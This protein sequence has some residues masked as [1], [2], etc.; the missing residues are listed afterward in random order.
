MR[1]RCV[2]TKT[3][4]EHCGS[5]DSPCEAK[6]NAAAACVAG[7]CAVG[8]CQTGFGNCD[9]NAE[10]GCE[11]DTTKSKDH[12]GACE[13]KC[14]TMCQDSV[15]ND[16]IDITAGNGHTCAILKDGSVWCWGTNGEGQ[17][18]VGDVSNRL[19]PTKVS[20]PGPATAVAAGVGFGLDPGEFE[21]HTCAILADKSLYCWGANSRGQLGTGDTTNA[22]TP[23][24]A[25]LTD[26]TRLSVGGQHTCATRANND[27]Y[28][29]G[30]NNQGQIGDGTTT[31]RSVPTKVDSFVG[32]FDAGYQHTCRVEPDGDNLNCW[33]DNASGQ[34]GDGTTNDALSPNYVLG[35]QDVE[36][37]SLGEFFSCARTVTTVQ[38]WGSNESGKLGIGT[39]TTELTPQTLGTVGF[40]L[41]RT[42]YAHA[43]G[44]AAGKVVMWGSNSGGQLGDNS[45]TDS[46]VPK[47]I[48][49]P[50]ATNLA[51]G[52]A[53]SCALTTAGVVLCWGTRV[54][55]LDAGTAPQD[56]VPTPVS[57][58]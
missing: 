5:C 55:E 18:G 32:A 49:L 12:C 1:Q 57:W 42:G 9:T 11:T 27:L 51:L 37:L 35:F 15:C 30:W 13:T 41:I 40:T 52:F 29:W 26:V 6:A 39:T 21:S 36:E 14:G 46:H 47:D 10:N 28:C 34:L 24:V 58:P 56:L 43:G 33:G 16:P 31:N 25:A 38:C 3:S 44:I 4:A 7:K 53:H 23:K 17:L 19:T 48:N 45:N 2:D 20:L 8:S 50:N 54:A 22:E